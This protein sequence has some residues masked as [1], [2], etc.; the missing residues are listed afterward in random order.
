MSRNRLGSFLFASISRAV[1]ATP[2]AEQYVSRHPWPPQPQRRPL[3]P[4]TIFTCPSSPAKPSQPNKLPVYD[5]AAAYACAERNHDEVFHTA[6]GAVCHFAYGCGV[7]VVCYYNGYAE[8]LFELL[9][10]G[11]D[12]FP[13]KVGGIFY[14]AFVIVAVGCAYSH[15]F[16]FVYPAHGVDDGQQCLDRRVHVVV[17]VGITFL[18]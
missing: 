1:R 13:F 9:S 14:C 2:V 8:C 12:S 16:Y 11:N 3:P 10:Y 6:C 17:E 7:G 15:G 4:R 18:S 5:N